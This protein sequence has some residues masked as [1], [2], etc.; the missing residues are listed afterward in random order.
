MLF[1]SYNYENFLNKYEMGYLK[2]LS[3]EKNLP[4]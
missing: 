4:K 1:F 3:P 2:G